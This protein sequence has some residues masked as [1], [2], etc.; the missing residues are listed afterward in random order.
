MPV[1]LEH[2]RNATSKGESEALMDE[3]GASK[4]TV[5]HTHTSQPT[6]PDQHQLL[7]FS[8]YAWPPERVGSHVTRLIFVSEP[9]L[10]SILRE[11]GW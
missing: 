2:A 3:R 7:P 1:L 10:V 4:L 5:I 9:E 6:Q 8:P 11:V